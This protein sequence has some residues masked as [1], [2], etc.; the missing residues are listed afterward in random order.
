M[1]PPPAIK[2]PSPPPSAVKAAAAAA[3]EVKERDYFSETL[4]DSFMYTTGLGTMIG[5]NMVSTFVTLNF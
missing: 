3:V 1:W 4:K 2:D 5:K